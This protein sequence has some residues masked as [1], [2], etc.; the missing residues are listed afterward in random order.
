[1]WSVCFDSDKGQ[2][3]SKK[4]PSDVSKVTTS[5]LSAHRAGRIRC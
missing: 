1:M 2:S 3:A 5:R 4:R